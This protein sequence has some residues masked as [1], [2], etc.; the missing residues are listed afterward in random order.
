MTP[1]SP[2]LGFQA[3]S[4]SNCNLWIADGWVAQLRSGVRIPVG[5]GD[6][7]PPLLTAQDGSR[8]VAAPSTEGGSFIGGSGRNII[9]TGLTPGASGPALPTGIFQ[10]G[11]PGYFGT[12][13]FT[14]Q[15]TNSSAATISDGTNIIATLSTGDTA[16]AGN[17]AATSYG[18]S[19]YHG[20]AAF[21]LAAAAEEGAP[22][23]IPA[24]VCSVSAGTA[25]AGN[26]TPSSAI[27]AAAASDANWTVLVNS[28]GTSDLKHSGTIMA[29]RAV[30]SPYEIAGVYEANSAGMAA[31][32]S[33]DPWRAFLQV[34]PGVVRAGFAYVT[35]SET[36][37][38]LSAVAGPFFATAM[39]ADSSTVFH[40]PIVQSDG[41]GSLVQ[42]HSGLL[43]WTSAVGAD[44]APGANGTGKTWIN[45]TLA[46][47]TAL[48]DG[49]RADAAK[50]YNITF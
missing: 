18:Q 34:V 12:G 8:F 20:G 15:V 11:R 16:P 44:G 35:L 25:Q 26:Y 2:I 45:I 24:C 27:A 22:G 42:L 37:G 1:A 30:G 32:N 40:I 13:I 23:A 33:G 39:P 38:V 7:L 48:S 43:I 10:P 3:F 29:S 6:D 41:L 5:S 47:Y 14:L 36:A 31:C 9:I 28:D 46:A 50:I 49:D 19:T 21:T 17:Y 4:D